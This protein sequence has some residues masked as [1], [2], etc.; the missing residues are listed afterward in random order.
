MSAHRGKSRLEQIQVR[1]RQ[2]ITS[3]QQGQLSALQE[4]KRV[5]EQ[6]R[7]KVNE[8]R[9]AIEALRNKSVRS[10]EQS[11]TLAGGLDRQRSASEKLLKPNI[12]YRSR[13]VAPLTE[14]RRSAPLNERP[15]PPVE[16]EARSSSASKVHDRQ[17]A[18]KK[19][20]HPL[21]KGNSATTSQPSKPRATKPDTAKPQ[22]DTSSPPGPLRDSAEDAFSQFEAHAE[23]QRRRAQEEAEAEEREQ[24]H[25]R[26]IEAKHRR[27]KL[28]A[29]KKRQEERQQRMKERA[30]AKDEE[31][32]RKK[33]EAEAAETTSQHS[34]DNVQ[35]ASPERPL[36]TT[37]AQ[38]RSQHAT[39]RKT[40]ARKPAPAEHTQAE[41]PRGD[42]RT[43]VATPAPTHSH[44]SD[45]SDKSSSSS[46]S[47]Q[48]APR[49][50]P[51][52]Q[53]AARGR[54]QVRSGARA[55]GTSATSSASGRGGGGGGGGSGSG[56]RQQ[57]AERARPKAPAGEPIRQMVEEL[58]PDGSVQMI[59]LVLYP[60]P[61]CGRNF[62]QERL[63]AHKRACEANSK[64][65]RKK[66]DMTKQRL[67][68]LGQ[69]AIRMAKNASKTEVKYKKKAKKSNWRA[70][71]QQ[72]IAAIQ[73]AKG[74]DVD[75]PVVEDPDLVKCKFCGRTFNE[76]AANR[77]IP[78]CERNAK[79]KAMAQ[80]GN[81]KGSKGTRRRR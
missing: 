70:K 7:Q 79:K 31:R 72:F 74:A 71:H 23:Q 10:R 57:E 68:D 16:P 26:A 17:V 54:R 22:S 1:L 37:G 27:K 56:G 39:P 75:V 61:I 45:T 65:K 47:S 81:S 48:R 76:D 9:R 28:E 38:K 21:A 53:P 51:T 50:P 30:K 11:Y 34:N 8:Q 25:Q 29:L 42:D 18:K 69:D 35:A 44:N 36:P 67:N 55:K 2:Q 78:V 14:E 24:E 13:R 19:V 40:P 73:S 43:D 49:P 20:K 59:E 60:C 46:S 58:M 64:K 4:R 80:G 3:A 15:R 77:H 52:Q 63:D 62:K 5:L 6:E 66:F 12:R 41:A 33:Q 32:L